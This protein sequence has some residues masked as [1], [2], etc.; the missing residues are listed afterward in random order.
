MPDLRLPA[1]IAVFGCLL[2]DANAAPEAP[3]ADGAALYR[4]HCAACH[5]GNVPRAPHVVTFNTMSADA[6]LGALNEGVMQAQAQALTAAERET[7]AHHLAGS[8]VAP[9]LP[10]LACAQPLDRIGEDPAAMRGWGADLRNSRHLPGDASRIGIGNLHDLRLK[11]VFA[12]PGAT[13]ARSQPLVHD[14]VVFVGSQD[15]TVYALSMDSGCAYWTY[16]AGAEVRSS[17]SLGRLP[18]RTGPVLFMGDFKARVHAV[19]ALT[20]NSLWTQ[21]IGDHPD[22]TITGSLKLYDGRL[23]VPVSSSEWASA[24]DPAYDCCTFRG[25]VVA[26]AAASG[27]LIWRT[28]SIPRAPQDTGERNS[29]GATRFAPAGAPVWNSPTI[30]AR[31]GLLYVGTGEAYTSPAADTSDAVRRIE[32]GADALRTWISARRRSCGGARTGSCSWLARK[33]AMSMHWIR[34]ATAPWSG[35]PRSAGAALPAACTGA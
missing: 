30:D 35:T 21:A 34:T 16:D 28:H 10:P 31:R 11:W 4:Q 8:A 3:A 25:S 5:D 14:G 17:L 18:E 29:Q 12:Y 1:L 26:L 15:G 2:A 9:A 6:I 22:A 24:A 27:E 13:R 33:A 7:V 20:G 23:Y 19:D 32:I